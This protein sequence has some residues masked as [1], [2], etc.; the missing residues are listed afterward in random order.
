MYTT[1]KYTAVRVYTDSQY[2]YDVIVKNSQQGVGDGQIDAIKQ[3]LFNNSRI[4][5]TLTQVN[6]A[7]HGQTAMLRTAE[8]HEE[9]Q[10]ILNTMEVADTHVINMNR[11]IS[12]T[13]LEMALPT[14]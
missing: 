7:R 13:F 5:I 11:V 12:V 4:F 9:V 8:S 10:E 14:L 6:L 3:L 1:T 2:F